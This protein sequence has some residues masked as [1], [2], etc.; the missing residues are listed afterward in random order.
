MLLGK[1]QSI[2]WNVGNGF[3][4]RIRHSNMGSRKIILRRILKEQNI[5]LR[6]IDSSKK[7]NKSLLL[8][9]LTD[10]Y[11]GTFKNDAKHGLGI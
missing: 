2:Y 9:K 4:A 10:L 8:S 3:N 7:L 5:R 1:W 6:N 11:I